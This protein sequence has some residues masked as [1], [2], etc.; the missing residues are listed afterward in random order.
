MRVCSQTS[1][2]IEPKLLRPVEILYPFKSRWNP[3]L[4]LGMN[5]LAAGLL[6]RLSQRAQVGQLKDVV[7]KN[8]LP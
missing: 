6:L 1:L 5:P 2:T 3:S 7:Q 8:V 4:T